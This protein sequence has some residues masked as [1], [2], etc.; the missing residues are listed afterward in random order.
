VTAEEIVTA[1]ERAR[2]EPEEEIRIEFDGDDQTPQAL[3]A[4]DRRIDE[5]GVH[6]VCL[7]VENT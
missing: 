1:L 5:Y 7:V 6:Y 2:V 3:K 4:V